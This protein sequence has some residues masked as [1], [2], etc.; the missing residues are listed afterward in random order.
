MSP[1]FS[2]NRVPGSAPSSWKRAASSVP[3]SDFSIAAV[4]NV[5]I[6]V[7]RLMLCI[8]R[9]FVRT[10]CMNVLAVISPGLKVLFERVG[11]PEVVNRPDLFRF[12]GAGAVIAC[13]HV[14]WADSLGWPMRYT[15]DSYAIWQKRNCSVQ[16]YRDGS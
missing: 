11:K 4:R 5:A 6:V 16:R 14:G 12:G 3:L 7:L 10:C 1:N 2:P 15:Q 8:E 13:N 9:A